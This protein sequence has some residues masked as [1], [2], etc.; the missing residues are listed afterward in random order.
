[1]MAGLNLLVCDLGTAV[2][3]NTWVIPVKREAEVGAGATHGATLLAA[4]V[5]E[6]GHAADFGALNAFCE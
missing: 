6:T 2:T 3:A 4:N 1:M 5:V